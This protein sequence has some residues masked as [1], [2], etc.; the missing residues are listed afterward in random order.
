MRGMVYVVAD[1]I[2]ED[3]DLGA[4]LLRGAKFARSLPQK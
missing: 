2:E 3:D 4:W 1:G